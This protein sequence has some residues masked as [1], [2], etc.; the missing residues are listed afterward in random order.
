MK[1]PGDENAAGLTAAQLQLLRDR[2]ERMRATTLRRLTDEEATARSAE[3]LSEPMD[4][5]ELSREQ[6]DAALFTERDR[7][8]LRD[9]DDA[10]AKF[11]TGQYGLS[12]RSGEPIGFRRLEALPWAR[13]AADEV[14]A[15]Q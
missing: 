3:S 6:G 1:R 8:L 12:E 7:Q 10:L 5:A 11:E 9:V 13:L 15:R 2:L 4:A 14:D